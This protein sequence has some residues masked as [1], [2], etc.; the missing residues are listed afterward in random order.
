MSLLHRIAVSKGNTVRQA[1]ANRVIADLERNVEVKWHK[2]LQAEIDARTGR[3]LSGR[4]LAAR[5]SARKT[6]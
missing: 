5:L 1:N 2:N 4:L 3:G 6:N